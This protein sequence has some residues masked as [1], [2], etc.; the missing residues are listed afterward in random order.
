M[1]LP[2]SK[3]LLYG[4]IAVHRSRGRSQVRARFVVLGGLGFASPELLDSPQALTGLV[5]RVEC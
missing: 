2:R 4:T 1:Y 5:P 3:R